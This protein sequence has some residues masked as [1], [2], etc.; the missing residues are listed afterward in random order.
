MYKEI[1]RNI[2]MENV[3]IQLPSSPELETHV[4][5]LKVYTLS[6]HC[7]RLFLQVFQ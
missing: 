3:E 6:P 2:L 7:Q 1:K 5:L 4:K